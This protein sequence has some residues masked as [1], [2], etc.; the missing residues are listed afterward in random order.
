VAVSFIGPMLKE[1]KLNKL[2]DTF[3]GGVCQFQRYPDNNEDHL[4]KKNDVMWN[5]K[6]SKKKSKQLPYMYVLC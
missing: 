3:A 2:T 4:F 1:N 6:P 5:T